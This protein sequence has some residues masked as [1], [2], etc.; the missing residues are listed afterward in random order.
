MT[1]KNNPINVAAF[2]VLMVIRSNICSIK[3]PKMGD[4]KMTIHKINEESSVLLLPFRA[5]K[6]TPL[7]I[8]LVYTYYTTDKDLEYNPL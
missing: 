7:L 6:Q 1:N 4:N 5:I 3:I 2:L 8:N